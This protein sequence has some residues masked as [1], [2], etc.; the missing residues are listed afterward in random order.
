MNTA[1][2]S[3][4]AEAFL[5]GAKLDPEYRLATIIKEDE[6]VHIVSDGVHGGTYVPPGGGLKRTQMRNAR[7]SIKRRLADGTAQEVE[8]PESSSEA[9]SKYGSENDSSRSY[10]R[11]VSGS[12]SDESPSEYEADSV[13]ARKVKLDTRVEKLLGKSQMVFTA[14]ECKAPQ[15]YLPRIPPFPY[16]RQQPEIIIKPPPTNALIAEDGTTFYEQM[17]AISSAEQLRP[18]MVVFAMYTG[19]HNWK[20]EEFAHVGWI[21]Y[22]DHK[23]DDVH[24]LVD[25]SQSPDDVSWKYDGSIKGCKFWVID[26]DYEGDVKDHRFEYNRKDVIHHIKEFNSV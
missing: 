6:L 8:Q 18:N 13:G 17:P 15:V 11:E 12:S 16:E 10:S 26:A 2:R 14:I 19:C 1:T 24:F 7:R 3:E 9:V 22:V 5:Q 20:P 25:E 21:K 4:D 23:N